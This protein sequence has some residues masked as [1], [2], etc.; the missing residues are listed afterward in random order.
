MTEAKADGQFHVATLLGFV[1]RH[2]LES[3]SVI[4]TPCE[5]ADHAPMPL[6]YFV[7]GLKRHHEN[8]AGM[9]GDWMANRLHGC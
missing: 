2:S 1:P 9:A 5:D 4:V 8:L 3:P 6:A 7:N